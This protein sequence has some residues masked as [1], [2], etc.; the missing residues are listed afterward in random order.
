[1]TMKELRRFGNSDS[2]AVFYECQS[3][4]RYVIHVSRLE[5]LNDAMRLQKLS[6]SF[7]SDDEGEAI[8]AFA[9][10]TEHLSD[11]AA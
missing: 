11:L 5:P 1:M 4:P 2:E 7:A 9:L 8:S 10:A 6:A 3:G